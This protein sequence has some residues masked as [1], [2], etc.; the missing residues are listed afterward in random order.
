[1][2]PLSLYT[3]IVMHL[4]GMCTRI[5]RDFITNKNHA[6]YV[7]LVHQ[8]ERHNL[9]TDIFNG[10]DKNVVNMTTYFE[11]IGSISCVTSSFRSEAAE[12]CALLCC[13]ARSSGNFLPTF[14]DN[15]SVRSPGLK[16]LFGFMHRE[17]GTDRLSR[18]V[19]KELPL[20]AA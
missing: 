15:I 16:N 10:R 2:F 4:N 18:K 11:E 9:E 7:I 14:R 5:Y 6:L 13:Y 3:S 20:L 12:N 8:P 1:M 17:D 19:G